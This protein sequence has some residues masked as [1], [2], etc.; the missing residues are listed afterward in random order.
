MTADQIGGIIRALATFATGALV[1]K[2]A[3]DNNTA[4]WIVGGAVTIGVAGW[5]W[6]TNRPQKIVDTATG[7]AKAS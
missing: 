1:A 7:Q 5:S 4:V 2:G 6:W 3:I